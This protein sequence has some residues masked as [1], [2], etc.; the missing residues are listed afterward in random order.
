MW[1][2]CCVWMFV[3]WF[4]CCIMFWLVW[5]GVCM[6]WC[7][8]VV[9]FDGLYVSVGLFLK[10]VELF[11]FICLYVLNCVGCGVDVVWMC[12]MDWFSE[13][14]VCVFL[15]FVW[16]WVVLVVVMWWCG[17]VGFAVLFLKCVRY[18][19]CMVLSWFMCF[20][21]MM[22]W[23]FVGCVFCCCDV[24]LW[25]CV[26]CFLIVMDVVWM[27][28]L[29]SWDVVFLMC[30]ILCWMCSSCV[31]LIW[32]VDVLR[33]CVLELFYTYFWNGV[34]FVCLRLDLCWRVV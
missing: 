19:V 9:F 25:L 4:G 14:C 32:C 12:L 7:V 23:L 17:L 10:L 21:V 18:C 24:Y 16:W 6:C 31:W 27:G 22:W 33:G 2:W 28:G 29:F 11:V 26:V 34:E 20:G 5:D 13:L 1:C 3:C 8:M 15:F 30:W